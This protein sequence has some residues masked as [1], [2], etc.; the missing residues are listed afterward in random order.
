M[1]LFNGIL[2][3]VVGKFVF[4]GH[5][6][7]SNPSSAAAAASEY[8]KKGLRGVVKVFATTAS[9]SFSLPWQICA[10]T[11]L[12]ASGFVVAPLSARRVLTNAHAVANHVQV[13]LR[14]ESSPRKFMAKV[15]VVGHECDIALLTVEDD[16]FWADGV[17]ALE[18]GDLPLMQENVTVVGFPLG[19]DNVCVTKGVASRLDLQTYSHGQ[20][21]LLTVQTD[22]PINSGNSGGPV[23]QGDKVVGLAFQSLIN[24]GNTGYVIPIPIV[25]HFLNDL[26][27]HGGK[28]TGF[29]EFGISFQCLESEDMKRS[30]GMHPKEA[31]GVY[32]TDTAPLHHAS[33]VL[34]AGDVLTSVDGHQVADDG[35]FL[36]PGQ[37]VRIS[38]SYLAS[39]AYDG[40]TVKAGI[41][42]DGRALVIPVQVRVPKRLVPC[43]SH[44]EKPKYYIFA[45]MV[46]TRL[47]EFYL[48]HSYGAAWASKAPLRLCEAHRDS[49]SAVGQEV[50]VLSKVLS[51]TV[52]QG[53]QGYCGVQVHKVNHAKVHNLAHL[54]N[55]VEGCTADYIKFEL[56]L[57]Q[58]IVL[59]TANSRA[60]SVDILLANSIPRAFSEGLLE[61]ELPADLPTDTSVAYHYG[62]QPVAN[63][64]EMV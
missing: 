62:S 33:K 20:C 46:F 39:I 51:S 7:D 3:D 57:K 48:S 6:V 52:N 41:W 49:M 32:I 44:D 8:L 11:K 14:K 25:R 59:N 12:T 23:L 34:R 36:F 24:A 58:V 45:G 18:L 2:D 50:V 64:L 38:F 61:E 43:H 42:R 17:D 22:A 37:S 27:R 16:D 28:Y 63:S 9:P 47:T 55:L 30:L 40:D 13:M 35:T 4:A 19:G 5:H 1:R 60:A 21:N 29:P 31:T 54:A 56:D 15:L 53:F 10:Q 26:E